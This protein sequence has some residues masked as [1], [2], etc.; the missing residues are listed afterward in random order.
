LSE[1]NEPSLQSVPVIK[2]EQ[3]VSTNLRAYGYDF[4]RQILRV[5]FKE[6]PPGVVYE[7]DNFTQKDF[8]RFL[9]SSSRG[10]FYQTVIRLHPERYPVRKVVCEGWDGEEKRVCFE[11]LEVVEVDLI[12]YGAAIRLANGDQVKLEGMD[13]TLEQESVFAERVVSCVNACTG[14]PSERLQEV[15]SAGLTALGRMER[16]RQEEGDG[17]IDAP[18]GCLQD[19]PFDGKDDRAIPVDDRPERERA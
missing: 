13:L 7:V 15:I 9:N 3:T 4:A 19:I 11:P 18:G 14:I 5:K 17:L 10:S 16:R 12:P 2:M 6:S 1:Q 8:D